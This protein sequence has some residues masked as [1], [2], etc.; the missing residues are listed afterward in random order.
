M[1]NMKYSRKYGVVLKSRILTLVVV[2]LGLLVPSAY[3]ESAKLVLRV[4]GD[5]NGIIN[6]I[7]LGRESIRIY[8]PLSANYS[9]N[10]G[11]QALTV[12]FEN[13]QGNVF[14]SKSD[15]RQSA[16]S[17][18]YDLPVSG[19]IGLVFDVEQHA[20]FQG[21]PDGDYKLYVVYCDK[22]CA[23]RTGFNER[24]VSNVIRVTIKGSKV[25]E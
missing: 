5:R 4:D 16:A 18:Q 8:T 12:Y 17:I 24:L 22:G 15:K 25:I 10:Q 19:V 14:F 20:L 23:W 21:V 2:Y 9:L 13:N 6:L 7:N 11:V 1:L 3:A